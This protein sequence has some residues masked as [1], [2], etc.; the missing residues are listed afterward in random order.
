MLCDIVLLETW[1]ELLGEDAFVI[2]GQVVCRQPRAP[3]LVLVGELY[4]V[5]FTVRVAVLAGRVTD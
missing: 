3:I 5:E 4:G 2:Y 1:V